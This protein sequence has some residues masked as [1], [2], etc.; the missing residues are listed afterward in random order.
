MTKERARTVEGVITATRLFRLQLPDETLVD[1]VVR[2]G[3]KEDEYDIKPAEVE[4]VLEKMDGK[5]EAA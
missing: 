1:A 2:L 4:Q 5:R 3:G